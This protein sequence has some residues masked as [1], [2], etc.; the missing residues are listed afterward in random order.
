M[1]TYITPNANELLAIANAVQQQ[2]GL[3]ALRTVS[4]QED[5]HSPQQ[6]LAQL[7]PAAAVVLQ[8]GEVAMSLVAE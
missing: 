2:A 6:L 5:Q 7:V 1:L 8:Q 4:L 3:P